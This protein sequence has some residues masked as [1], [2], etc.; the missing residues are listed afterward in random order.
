MFRSLFA[1]A[2]SWRKRLAFAG[3]DADLLTG[4]IRENIIFGLLDASDEDVRNAVESSNAAEFVD[5]LPKA[6][7]TQIGPRGLRLSGGQRQRVALARA[8]IRRP[9]LLILDETTNA[10]DDVT[11]QA[12]HDAIGQLAGSSTIIIIGHRLNTLRT[13]DR[14]LVIDHYTRQA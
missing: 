8:L 7:D 5:K 14:T 2:R 1:E 9:E 12:I 10:V 11:E 13:A 3:Q 6:L 4:S